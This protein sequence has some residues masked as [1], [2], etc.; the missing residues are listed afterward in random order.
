[1]G[2]GGR[3][4]VFSA[5]TIPGYFPNAAGGSVLWGGV[6]P[7]LG[8][9][10]ARLVA[11]VSARARRGAAK[12]QACTMGVFFIWM[13]T[14]RIRETSSVSSLVPACRST[15]FTMRS[16]GFSPTTSATVA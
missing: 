13:K 6:I 14:W 3:R 15:K 8:G 10:I 1:M 12:S 4:R 2:V 5:K 16:Q 11:A 7:N 9:G